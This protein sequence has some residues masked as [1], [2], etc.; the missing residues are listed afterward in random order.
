[1]AKSEPIE[2]QIVV[3]YPGTRPLSTKLWDAVLA[4]YYRTGKQML[5]PGKFRWIRRQVRRGR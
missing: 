1:M 2:G 4:E 3:A 5:S